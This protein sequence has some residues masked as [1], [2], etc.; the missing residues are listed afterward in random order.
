[1]IPWKSNFQLFDLSTKVPPTEKEIQWCLL[2]SESYRKARDSID[3]LFDPK[4]L[5]PM[6]GDKK[7]R[8]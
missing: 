2:M 6:Q 1:M 5:G 7:G 3:N 8:K 4:L